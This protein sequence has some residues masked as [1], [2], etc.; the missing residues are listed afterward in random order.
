MEINLAIL[1]DEW[2]R[3]RALPRAGTSAAR[4]LSNRVLSD[5]KSKNILKSRAVYV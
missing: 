1:R 5:V 2:K 3:A 4:G